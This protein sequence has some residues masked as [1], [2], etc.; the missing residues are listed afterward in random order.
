MILVDQTAIPLA[1][2]DIMDHFGVS[3]QPVHGS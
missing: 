2:L 1:L 3:S